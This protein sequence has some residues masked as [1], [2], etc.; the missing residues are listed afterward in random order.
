ML[1]KFTKNTLITFFTRILQLILGIGT[2]VIIARVL[3]PEGKGIYS[4][5]ILLPALL[6]IFTNLGIGPASVYYIGKKKYAPKEVFGNNIISS[7][8]ISIFTVLVGLIIIFFFSN[9]L[10]PGVAKE[11]LFLALSLI[12]FQIFLNFVINILLSLQ[13]IKKYNLIQL[14][15][16]FVFLFLIIIFLLGLHFGI[17]AT[18]IA[19]ALS[20]FIA[21]IILFIQT[22]KETGGLSLSLNKDLSKDL[23]SYGVKSYLGNIATFLY[24]RIDMWMIN[25]FL[26]PL[27]VGLYSIAVVLSEKIQL[28]SQSAGTL[29]FPKVS[30]ETDGKRLKEFTPLVCRN[31]LFVTILIAIF[32]F[33][34]SRWL[35]VLFYSERFLESVLPFQIL[36]IGAMAVSSSGIIA[37]DLA[38]RGKPIINTY[39]AIISLVLNILLNIILIPTLGIIGAAWASAISYAFMLILKIIIYSRISRNKIRD[40][41]FIKKSDFRFYKNLATL[42]LKYLRES[43]R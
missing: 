3:G 4:L 9:S 12:P 30:S 6:I 13:K 21:C 38:G 22:R 19:G 41:L 18:I 42:L 32:F 25:I 29:L 43:L 2:S 5:A 27:A 33:F 24:L 28:I 26:N 1:G 36:L 11:Y 14:I 37:K 10:F 15:H 20:L 40:I 17:K 31:V 35:I 39:I 34:L 16:T 8:F 7:I 23:L